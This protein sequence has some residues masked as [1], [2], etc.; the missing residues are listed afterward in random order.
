MTLAQTSLPANVVDL[1][2]LAINRGYKDEVAVE[3]AAGHAEVLAALELLRST[4]RPWVTGQAKRLP[5]S[6]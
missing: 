3:L 1:Y 6:T 4:I 2:A 5:A